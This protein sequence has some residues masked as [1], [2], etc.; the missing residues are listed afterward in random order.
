MF[1]IP[2]GFAHGMLALTDGAI[3]CYKCTDFYHPGDEGG[4]AW[5]D[6]EVSVKWPVVGE[7]PGN[8][9]ASG[10]TRIQC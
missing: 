5:N 4:I 7:Y 3:F 9:D 1:L 8:A 2:E 10:Y 6:P